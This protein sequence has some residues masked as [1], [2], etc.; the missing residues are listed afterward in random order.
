M[1]AVAYR[2]D[3]LGELGTQYRIDIVDSESTAATTLTFK[4]DA[5]GFKLEYQSSGSDDITAGIMG[6]ILSVSFLVED[7]IKLAFCEQLAEATPSRFYLKIYRDSELFWQGFIKYD[8]QE[9]N[10]EYYPFVFTIKAEDRFTRL[11]DKTMFTGITDPWYDFFSIN[12]GRTTFQYM[13]NRFITRLRGFE[14]CS[15]DGIFF[16]CISEWWANQIEY[17]HYPVFT[18]P[19]NTFVFDNLTVHKYW[20]SDQFMD[21]YEI[22]ELFLKL[23]NLRIYQAKGIYIFENMF[24]KMKSSYYVWESSADIIPDLTVRL[25]QKYKCESTEFTKLTGTTYRYANCLRNS[26]MRYEDEIWFSSGGMDKT[27]LIE[28]ETTLG[29][30]Y[31]ADYNRETMDIGTVKIGTMSQ[32][33]DGG[34][35]YYG[36]GTI[37]SKKIYSGLDETPAVDWICDSLYN[38]N[39]EEHAYCLERD[40]ISMRKHAL[41]IFN[42]EIQSAVFSAEKSLIFANDD[43]YH[44]LSGSF[45]AMEEIWNGSWVKYDRSYTGITYDSTETY[46]SKT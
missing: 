32:F 12:K 29:D 30:P 42:G 25:S 35:T 4:T 45:S 34:V 40:H 33:V 1:S 6:S 24:T 41:R 7:S 28:T 27:S 13:M 17:A 20:L 14:L 26:I 10:D 39:P 18:K 44:F 15:D 43:E 23:F 19:Y 11:K 9:F 16:E 38:D 22:L 5:P 36:A 3:F 31:T 37:W 46:I 8:G 2:C 21:E